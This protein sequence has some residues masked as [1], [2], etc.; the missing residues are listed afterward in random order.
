MSIEERIEKQEKKM[1]LDKIYNLIISI[2]RKIISH[3]SMLNFNLYLNLRIKKL[4]KLLEKAK[5]CTSWSNKLKSKLGIKNSSNTDLLIV[6]YQL[7]ELEEMK[8]L[9]VNDKSIDEG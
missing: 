7:K 1:S 5:K 9:I 8:K 6:S 3:E 4:E 2:D